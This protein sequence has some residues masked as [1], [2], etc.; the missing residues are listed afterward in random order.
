MHAQRFPRKPS[1]ERAISSR[2]NQTATS[3]PPHRTI[4]FIPWLYLWISLAS[5][6]ISCAFF[7][8]V[9]GNTA[10]RLVCSNSFRELV[11]QSGELLH[12]GGNLLSVYR[13]RCG[14]SEFET[15]G[16]H[17]AMA[18]AADAGR[19]RTSMAATA[20]LP[21]V[22]ATLFS[23][24]RRD[25]SMIMPFPSYLL[26]RGAILYQAPAANRERNSLDLSEP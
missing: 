2:L 23:K 26:S 10:A 24:L 1:K 6:S 8:K 14:L 3:S 9:T 22:P 5:F 17:L 15:G 11:R 21:A 20:R 19:Q 7:T 4:R 25:L 13:V 12:H 18:S 16:P